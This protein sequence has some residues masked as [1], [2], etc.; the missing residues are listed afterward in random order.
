M[1]WAAGRGVRVRAVR[2]D[3]SELAFDA[4]VRIDTPQELLYYRHGGIL[5]YVLHQL[6]HGREQPTVLS[7]GL[8]TAHLRRPGEAAPLEVEQGSAE[9]FPASDPPSY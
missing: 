3:G 7:G 9:S 8:A 2:E 1:P 6:M 5:A 4:R